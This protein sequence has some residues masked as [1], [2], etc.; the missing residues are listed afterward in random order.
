M[1]RGFFTLAMILV[2]SYVFAQPATVRISIL[3]LLKPKLVNLTI[4]D[5]SCSFQGQ[6]LDPGSNMSITLDH[7]PASGLE[8]NCNRVLIEVPPNF[9]RI[10]PGKL[11]FY[12]N[13]NTIVI[14]DT[15]PIE[16]AV[17]SIT[18]SEMSVFRQVEAWKAFAVVARTFLLSGSRHLQQHADF[19]DTTHCQVFQAYMPEGKLEDAV[20]TTH[21]LVLQYRQ[22][23]FRPYF[24]FSCGG[25]TA[26]YEEVWR[27]PA[28]DYPF[29]SVNCPG[30]EKDPD[31]KAHL[32]ANQLSEI[33][34]APWES[35][36][37]E[38]LRTLVGR[39]L[40]WKLLRSNSFR[41]ESSGDG[42]DFFGRGIG[43]RVGLCQ[44]GAAYLAE[45]GKT[46]KEI[47]SYYFPNTELRGTSASD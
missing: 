25:K 9:R 5:R 46:F 35:L 20:A 32:S 16:E 26:T 6:N 18:T 14:V 31:W 39:F 8:L 13:N 2:A 1:K 11:S 4:L 23:I 12:K 22:K 36:M 19:C 10:Y 42:Y 27:K 44:K 24:S 30:C 47:L 40:G 43:H 15:I 34:E 33:T 3:S 38:E 45:H 7:I 29:I 37:P 21:G 28:A 41:Y 17:E